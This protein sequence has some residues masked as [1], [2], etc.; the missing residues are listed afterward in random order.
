MASDSFKRPLS[1]SAGLSRRQFVRRAAGGAI[2]AGAALST[3]LAQAGTGGAIGPRIRPN[4]ILIITDQERAPQYWPEGWADANLPN[5][6]RLADHGLTF[7]RGFCNAAMC[8]PSRATL[9]TG[10]YLTQHGVEHTL[11]TNGSLSP[12][13][14]TLQPTTQNM[15][16]LL[17]SAGYNVQFRGKWHLSKD[18][19]GITDA[20]SA[21]DLEKFGF[22]GWQPP[23]SGQDTNPAHFGGGCAPYDSRWA[24]QAADFLRSDA[25]TSG[26]PFALIVSFVN[27]HDALAYPTGWNAQVGN[28]QN[29]YCYNYRDQA[30]ACFEQGISFPPTLDENL[31]LNYKPT[32]QAQSLLLLDYGLG[33]LS[34]ADD[35]INYVNFYAYL[36]KV[37]DQNIGT[38]LDALQANPGLYNNTWV[39]R[40]SDHGEMGLSHG[41]LRQKLFNAYE[42]TIRVPIVFSNPRYFPN[43]VQTNALASLIDIMPTL[44]TLANVPNPGQWTFKGHDLTPVITDAIQNPANPMASVQDSIL[45]MYD[46]DNPGS[47]NPQSIVR[48]PSHIRCIRDGRYK[49]A[50]YFDPCGQK[51]PQYELYDLLN[52]PQELHNMAHPANAAYYNPTLVAQMQAKLDAKMA[53][54]GTNFTPSSPYCG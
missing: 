5:R 12:N 30:P 22:Q 17:A 41:G 15:A 36:Q 4:I 1:S 37:V 9:F 31:L 26:Q 40:I 20:T 32:A 39:I 27:P 44:A 51:P 21:D 29:G 2:A 38:V 50:V 33:P 54:T 28:A 42:E 25:A 19:T 24:N 6:K 35:K 16:K 45:F 34:G 52:D 14:P 10:L 46:D 18:V 13:E 49:Y 8:S 47:P 11:T 48:E 3:T 43:G 7:T 53:Q 23:D